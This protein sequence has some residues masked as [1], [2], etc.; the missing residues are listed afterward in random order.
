MS[1]TVGVVDWREHESDAERAI[2]AA[3]SPAELEEARVRYLGR[4]SELAQA[5]RQVRDR[6]TGMAL[7][8]LR[9]RL[10]DGLAKRRADLE[11][12][13]LDRALSEDVVDVTLPGDELPL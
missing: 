4:K 3:A 6:E 13:E 10:E 1:D 5:L 7:N 2:A 8:S 11:R 12:A 9:D